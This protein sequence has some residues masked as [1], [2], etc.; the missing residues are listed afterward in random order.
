[1]KRTFALSLL[2]AAVIV[3]TAGS[4]WAHEEIN[5]KSFP[6]GTPT[7]FTLSAADEQKVDLVKVA[8]TAPSGVPLGATTKEPSGWAVDR[9]DTAITWTAG[10]GAG[11][12]P[13]HFE[14]W[15]FETDGA[16][17]PGTFNFKVSL[18]FAD[19]KTDDVQVPVTVLVGGKAAGSTTGGTSVAATRAA[20]DARSRANTALVLGIVAA[21]LALVALVV[22][23]AR[24][25]RPGVTSAPAGEGRQDW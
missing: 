3:V 9:T 12:K 8:L 22:L 21:V 17:Q 23:V 13:D 25:R 24:P 11:V 4:A 19:G 18:T 2:V 7:F 16:D 5:P 6:T 20:H 14:Q 1:M 10:N 15:S